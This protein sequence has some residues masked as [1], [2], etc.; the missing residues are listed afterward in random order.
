VELSEDEANRVV[1]VNGT[2]LDGTLYDDEP[3]KFCG[4]TPI[5]Y[6]DLY[7]AYACPRCVRWQ[8][9]KRSDPECIYCPGRPDSPWF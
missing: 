8:H 9:G 6:V 1:V 2:R 3:C 4:F 5:V 7:D